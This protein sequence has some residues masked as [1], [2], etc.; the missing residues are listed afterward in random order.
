M[1]ASNFQSRHQQQGI[2]TVL[3]VVLLGLSLTITI[4]VGLSNLRSSQE[5]G[6]SMHTQTVTQQRAWSAAEALREY[7]QEVT[8]DYTDWLEFLD[9][10][11]LDNNV[12]PA[13]TMTGFEGLQ[14]QF[15]G[16]DDTD[17]DLLKFSALVTAEAAP[18]TRIASKSALEITFEVVP[19]VPEEVNPPSEPSRN[20]ITFYDGLDVRGN[21]N[22]VSEAG[23]SY[24]IFVDGNV[25]VG[26]VSV[27]GIDVIRS[28]M[29]IEF[30]G[31]SGDFNELHASCDVAFGQTSDSAQHIK[32]TNNV[33]LWGGAR[34]SLIEANGFVTISSAGAQDTI[35]SRADVDGS[36]SCAPGAT[37]YCTDRNLTNSSGVR[38]S[39]GMSVP[40]VYTKGA[41]D[42][43]FDIA[44]DSAVDWKAEK[45]IFF[46]GTCPGNVA[47]LDA[48]EGVKRTAGSVA[49]DCKPA[50]PSVR[51][52]AP[53]I[54]P[55]VLDRETF[56]AN[57]FRDVANFV[58]HRHAG[59]TR[60][61]VRGITGIT[62]SGSASNSADVRQNGYYFVHF[63]NNANYACP[64][65]NS[66]VENCW[67]LASGNWGGEQVITYN[68]SG[69]RW[70]ILAWGGWGH[71][72]GVIFFDGNLLANGQRF[73]ATLIATGNIIADTSIQLAALNY[74]GPNS[75]QIEGNTYQGVCNNNFG[76]SVT[77]LCPT[78]IYNASGLSGLGNFALKAG[79]CPTSSPGTCD[80]SDYIGGNIELKRTVYGVIKA[81]NIFKSSAN[82][83]LVGY[84]SA[85]A[86]GNTGG[87]V[88]S[89]GAST[90]IDL[91]D[92]PEWFDPTG[93][94]VDPGD[95]SGGN[96]NGG[97][98]TEEAGSATLLWTRYL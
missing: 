60:V 81:G 26:S 62:D 4:L 24:D 66:P 54:Q 43:D 17:P 96:G 18:G 86:L 51:V 37:R 61:I 2:A 47:A 45:S 6:V 41:I 95:G 92:L 53:V 5:L 80:S 39:G 97:G 77:E 36:A 75:R 52:N 29:S 64:A 55:V 56:D 70:T 72:P 94:A 63:N 68:A 27:T 9:N 69:N 40:R 78:G 57:D 59:Q 38:L 8:A 35:W 16:V 7:L 10:F 73:T 20:V 32:A 42:S 19:P 71:A 91:S 28:T 67:R 11:D 83:S 12:Y 46:N 15:I 76:Y 58:Y 33:C 14:A 13:I 88:N 74:V 98:G 22:V 50:N 31:G 90:S 48:V 82:T 21:I 84:V 85:L 25:T 93:G 89:M 65:S 79:S 34:S 23:K 44:R 87:V 49:P 30:A 3:I 1:H